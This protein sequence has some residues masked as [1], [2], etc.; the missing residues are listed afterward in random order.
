LSISPRTA[1][2]TGAITRFDSRYEHRGKVYVTMRKENI[3]KLVRWL[4]VLFVFTIPFE[5]AGTSFASGSF[6]IAKAAGLLFTV[7]YLMY[8]NPFRRI[9]R[10]PSIPS[11]MWCFLSYLTIYLLSGAFLPKEYLFAFVARFITLLQLI[12]FFYIASSLLQDFQTSRSTILS[13]TI[14][15]S[16]L[17]CCTLLQLP[18]FYGTFAGEVNGRV[19]AMGQNPNSI[20]E[21]MATGVVG[22]TGLVLTRSF[23]RSRNLFLILLTAPL[24]MLLVKTGSRAAI[25]GLMIGFS[26]YPLLLVSSKR[27]FWTVLFSAFTIVGVIYIVAHDPLS[28]KRLLDTYYDRSVAGRNVIFS[29][30]IEMFQ[31]RPLLGW[32]PILNW[33]DLGSRLGEYQRDAHNLFLHLLL[34]VGLVGAIPFYIGL[35]FCLRG[36]WNAS[37][38]ALGPVFIALLVTILCINTANTDLATKPFWLMLALAVG[39]AAGMRKQ[40]RYSSLLRAVH[41][42]AK[43]STEKWPY[44]PVVS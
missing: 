2:K 16:V 31:E 39:A 3:P 41:S 25:I 15:V 33:Y 21:L 34:E 10:L 11:E 12:G 4:L 13:Y 8:Y 29:A 42:S 32:H 6:S 28:T 7:T 19:T 38:G 30:G 24:L 5:A 20:G 43:P 37:N 44:S 22:L 1:L 36:A 40:K 18:G 17:A 23:R 26:L 35:M 27:K 9:R 14:A